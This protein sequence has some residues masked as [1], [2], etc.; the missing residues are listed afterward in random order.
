[1][2]KIACLREQQAGA[3][4]QACQHGGLA[5]IICTGARHLV[6]LDACMMHASAAKPFAG[7]VHL[8]KLR[9]FWKQQHLCKA[10]NQG[11]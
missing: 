7:C 11:Y 6:R 10:S 1:M 9:L 3:G 4:G 8:Q 2:W 5:L